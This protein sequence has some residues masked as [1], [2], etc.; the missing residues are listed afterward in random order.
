MRVTTSVCVR[1]ERS[2]SFKC[3]DVYMFIKALG[4]R[5]FLFYAALLKEGNP[6]KGLEL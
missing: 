3:L 4:S 1:F 6:G 2:L 5:G